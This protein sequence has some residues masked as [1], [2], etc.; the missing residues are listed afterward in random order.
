MHI[1]HAEAGDT[2][3]IDSLSLIP[4][5]CFVTVDSDTLREAFIVMEGSGEIVVL[6]T[7]KDATFYY[8]N[9]PVDLQKT[10]YQ[11]DTSLIVK[12]GTLAP[13]RIYDVGERRPT[14]TVFF[15]GLNKSGSLSRGVTVGNNQDAVLNSNLNLQLSGN[16]N[17]NTTIRASITD[18]QIPVYAE[19]V[20]QSLRE[21]DRVFIEVENTTFG[22]VRAGDF[23]IGPS[24]NHFLRFQKR[25]SGAGIQSPIKLGKGTL[26]ITGVGALARGEFHRNTFR[27]QE[28][29]QGPYKL[30]GKN[31][32]L[33]LIVISGSERVYIDGRLLVRGLENDYT[34]DYSTGE[35]TFTA[36]RPI[37][38]DHRIVVEFQYTVQNY[39]RSVGYGGLD[40]ESDQWNHHLYI[41]SEQDARNQPIFSMSDNDRGILADAGDDP[42]LAVSPSWNQVDFDANRILYRITDSL[43]LDTVFV[44]STN[45]DDTLYQVFF[46]F[47]GANKGNYIPIESSANG[48]VYQFIAPVAGIPQGT[49]IPYSI[50]PGPEKIQVLSYAGG[51]KGKHQMEV[52]W[53]AAISNNDPNTFSDLDN[54]NHQG[55]ATKLGISKGWKSGKWKWR[56]GAQGEFQ[57]EQFKTVERI[58]N[59]E[60]SRDWNLPATIDS[61]LLLGSVHLNGT[62]GQGFLFRYKGSAVD[63][64]NSF[65]GLKNDL[66]LK[67]K[68]NGLWIDVTASYLLTQDT[69]KNT[70]FLRMMSRIQK[71]FVSGLYMGLWSSAE[72]NLATPRSEGEDQS[73]RFLHYKVY[74]GYGDTAKSF[75]EGGYF[76]NT[77]DTIRTEQWNPEA[78]ASG[79]FVRSAFRDARWGSLLM[80]IQNR[81]LSTTN[82]SSYI[83]SLTTRLQYNNRFFK[84][85]LNWNTFYE[86]G[87]GR[88]PARDFKYIRVPKGT[89]THVWIDY[90]GNGIEEVDEFEPAPFPDQGEYVRVFVLTR[91]YTPVSRVKF[92]QQ[93]DL[94]FDRIVTGGVKNFWGRFNLQTYYLMERR[95]W[96]TG[97]SNNLNPFDKSVADSLILMAVENFR[98]TIFFNRS[99][100]L[101]GASYTFQRNLAKNLLS[102]GLENQWVE[103]HSL[104]FR[105]LFLK[106]I[107]FRV[108]ADYGTKQNYVPD[109]DSRNY[110]IDSRSLRPVLSYQ[111]GKYLRFALDY[112]Y[113]FS[114]NN[115][116][117]QEQLTAHKTGGE[118]NFNH[119]K[120]V[121]LQGRVEVVNNTF[122]GDE[123]SP[124]GFEM[125]SGLRPGR[126]VLW[127]IGIQKNLTTFLQIVLNYEGRSSENVPTVHTGNVQVKAFF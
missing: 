20:S 75:V 116:E 66:R 113:Q 123:F 62:K 71:N 89:G 63:L 7:L 102:Y 79:F 50:L 38:K 72:N 37:T 81:E 104:N 112:D 56:A 30:I 126:N 110:L 64:S 67:Y 47:A 39:I 29:N 53:E 10:W 15:D 34:I 26:R 11:K 35:I 5:D 2:L 16:I 25:I 85:F 115:S 107:D 80:K 14:S 86:S 8:A 51:W 21:F 24:G 32:E 119:P 100:P 105:Y 117:E 101:Y 54:E 70:S 42:L 94:N 55:A 98:N 77:D 118:L 97:N 33:T 74:A 59:V 17:A 73:Y 114:S 125:L 82:D 28:G 19:G 52:N 6:R 121:N 43:G 65:R 3:R 60:F 120:Y 23:D 127:R 76:R 92:S 18:N 4:G 12:P 27:G 61:D 36:L 95:E 40:W 111:S 124:V 58:R 88:E 48:R 9:L 68:E 31:N 122:I 44:Y 83:R 41:Y 69:L 103:K 49:H 99:N 93:A 96:L 57:Q 1:N 46:S 90:N 45:P 87:I 22:K 13:S 109:F 108:T 91:Q 84:G 106:K 78:L